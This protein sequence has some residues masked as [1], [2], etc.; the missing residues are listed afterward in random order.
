[1][2]VMFGLE[3]IEF[4]PS[5]KADLK[6]DHSPLENI[7]KSIAVKLLFRRMQFDIEVNNRRKYHFNRCHAIRVQVYLKS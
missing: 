7:K 4:L 1:M 5:G 6:I 2:A 3:K